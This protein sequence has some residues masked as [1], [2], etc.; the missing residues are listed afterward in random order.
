MQDDQGALN[1]NIN[2]LLDDAMALDDNSQNDKPKEKEK[3]KPPK[4]SLP[5]EDPI[6]G[7]D[8]NSDFI[9]DSLQNADETLAQFEAELE[10]M[11]LEPQIDENV[12]VFDIDHADPPAGSAEE[13]PVNFEQFGFNDLNS[14]DLPGGDAPN[15]ADELPSV[16]DKP[17]QKPQPEPKL[18]QDEDDDLL[19]NFLMDEDSASIKEPEQDSI[20]VA[21]NQFDDDFLG[22]VVEQ[23][24]T[25]IPTDA[26]EAKK[27]SK[28]DK[29]VDLKV[30]DEA[31]KEELPSAEHDIPKA[32]RSSFENFELPTRPMWLNISMAAGIFVLIIGLL[33]QVI[34][35]RS[36]QLA[37]SFPGMSPMLS[38]FCE[39]FSCRYSG[40]ID[41]EQIQL[42]N[43]NVSTHPNQKN[44]LLISTAFVNKAS[45]NQPYPTIAIKL[46]DLSGETVATR[47]FRPEE[48]LENLYN[49]FLL[50]E[51]GTPVHITLAVLDPGND[52][53]NFEFS[54][55]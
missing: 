6:F 3:A 29:S 49:K 50:M 39:T 42:I 38:N 12:S 33:S 8:D 45:F 40:E 55:L 17:E 5:A 31:S 51:S 19:E 32:L 9:N 34:I 25:D 15:T 37:N 41:V 54:F 18:K 30:N 28:K 24:K 7:L 21:S 43:R 4:K 48:Y 14:D 52:A 13:E 47:Y 27:V 20:E 16:D 26:P 22:G 35:F 11:K 1:A 36:Y 46:S 23:V 44:A 10:D 2:A 53:V